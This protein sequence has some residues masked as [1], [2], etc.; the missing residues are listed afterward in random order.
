VSNQPR[1]SGYFRTSYAQD[2]ALIQTRMQRVSAVI[3]GI[4]LLGFPLV[5]SN[6]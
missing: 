5:A 4:V 1:A 2:V 3:F 6:F